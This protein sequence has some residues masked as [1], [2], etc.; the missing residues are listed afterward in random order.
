MLR[1]ALRWVP[2]AG[3]LW[4][5]LFPAL[6]AAAP[7][8][9]DS[10]VV[11]GRTRSYRL[12]IP[13]GLA[14]TTPAPI[15]LVLHGGGGN[16]RGMERL[17]GFSRLADR[18]RFIVV[19]PDAVDGNWVDGR[20]GMR[21]EAHRKGIDDVAFIAA[22]LDEVARRRPIDAKRVFATGISNGGIFS[23]YLAAN[24][25]D[26][27]VAIAPVA[28]GLADPFY[29][30]FAPSQP[31]SV[32]ILQ[33]T[34]DPL[35]PFDGGAVAWGGRGQIIAAD[36]T[37]AALAPAGPHAC[38]RR[39]RSPA[40]CRCE[41]RLPRALVELA[42][43]PTQNRSA[44]LCRGGR[45]PYLARRLAVSAESAHRRCLPRFR[46]QRGDLGI[47]QGPPAAV[48][49]ACYN[50]L[51]ACSTAA[52]WPGTFT[53]RQMPRTTLLPS[54]RKVARSMPMYLRPYMLFSTQVP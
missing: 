9:S 19:Y 45:R 2:A 52:T 5:A 32:F 15:V 3:W 23:H 21:T 46:R 6:A 43:R 35:M 34:A 10:I 29:R 40:R 30:A 42:R 17:T 11:D 50:A 25:A 8:E 4:L 38:T 51:A 36:E 53:L 13:A 41:R 31:V 1:T 14:G 28:G 7:T 20:V 39:H 24:L 22:L 16:G 33:G 37:R 54:I 12:H 47:L 44:A 48:N 49:G 27:I 18:E 26:R